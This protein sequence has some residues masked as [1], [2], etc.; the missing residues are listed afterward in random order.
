MA[1]TIE[2]LSGGIRFGTNIEFKL[3]A[4]MR[5]NEDA[6]A[7]AALGRRL[8]GLIQLMPSP[9]IIGPLVGIAEKISATAD[10]RLVTL[11]FYLSHDK[12]KEVAARWQTLQMEAQR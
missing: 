3:E 7:L 4:L 8:P 9:G 2:E 10:G 6:K 11:S 5:S 12:V 1:N